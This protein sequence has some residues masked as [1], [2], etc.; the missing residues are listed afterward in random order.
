MNTNNQLLHDLVKN[1]KEDFG[2]RF[3]SHY[4]PSVYMAPVGIIILGDH[5]HYNEGI[6][7]SA[8]LDRY[9]MVGVSKRDD[10]KALCILNGKKYDLNELILNQDQFIPAGVS[11]VIHII[12]ALCEI[13]LKVSGINIVIRE[14]IPRSFGIGSISSIQ[15]GLLHALNE[16]CNLNFSSEKIVEFSYQTELK[17][18]GKISNKSLHFTIS[19]STKGSLI[20]Y[21]LRSFKH[22]K[23]NLD[24]NDYEFIICNS[25]NQFNNPRETC[26]ERIH[27][28]EIGV[29][30]LRLYIWG[31][32]CLRDVEEEFLNKHVHMIP[33]QVFSKCMFN[34]S[35]RKRVIKSIQ[36]LSR[37]D[38]DE[39]GE[40][41]YSSH[42]SLAEEY[43]L[44]SEEQDYIVDCT[45][46]LQ[47][48]LGAKIISCSSHR[49]VICLV[50]KEEK[51]EV[52]K[53][54]KTKFNEKYSIE[55]EITDV[56]LSDKVN[57]VEL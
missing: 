33:H 13:S 29:K 52:K 51:N 38:L 16:K 25:N 26:N 6:I 31:I 22:K 41:L 44:G 47:G 55:L 56:N 24:E 1:M 8:S 12:K 20:N 10:E 49:T 46:N 23:I 37:K 45:K 15:I 40:N 43:N 18:I 53:I 7:L 57:K 14:N 30:G 36:D 19:N 54:L 35:E 32:K 39:F 42:K 4:K 2:N 5:T 48:V 50:K 27:E 28:C 34:V 17:N 9:S 3:E 21:D 11:H